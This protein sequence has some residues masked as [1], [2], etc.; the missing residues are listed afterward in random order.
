MRWYQ[1]SGPPLAEIDGHAAKAKKVTPKR[2]LAEDG[3][4]DAAKKGAEESAKRQKLSKDLIA[5]GVRAVLRKADDPASISRKEL[6]TTLEKKLGVSDLSE[7]KDAIKMAASTFMLA[8]NEAN[9][10]KMAA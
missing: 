7:W 10:M 1:R 2:P 5:K 6:R 3:E 9:E 4:D 8:I